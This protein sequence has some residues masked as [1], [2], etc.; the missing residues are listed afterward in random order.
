MDV[1]LRATDELLEDGGQ[2]CSSSCSPVGTEAGRAL[3][4]PG[5]SHLAPGHSRGRGSR[6]CLT[7][8]FLW[9]L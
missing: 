2:P 3:W 5:V 6:F 9:S 7:L 8:C 4:P 1:G